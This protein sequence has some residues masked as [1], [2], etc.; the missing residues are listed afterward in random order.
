[1]L[2]IAITGGLGAG[3]STA[4]RFFLDRGALLLSLDEIAHDVLAPGSPVLAQVAEAFGDEVLAPD[5]SLD[6][7]AL[8]E[9]AFCCQKCADRLDAIVHPQV[10]D[11]T[12]WRFDAAMSAEP[13]PSAV[14]LEIPLLVEAPSLCDLADE[15]LA[16]S[17][18]E[19]ERIARAVERGMDELDARHRIAVQATDEERELLASHVI[20]ND[21]DESTF[22]CALEEF[23]R[24][25]TQDY[26]RAHPDEAD[27]PPLR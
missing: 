5:G 25:V 18:P 10:V 26:A 2:V 14:V 22:A 16:I 20:V 12:R 27:G 17:A 3:K 19:E 1:M 15:V 4:A 13:S 23:W 8:A 21:G 24:Q 7:A 11:E 6:R 9:K